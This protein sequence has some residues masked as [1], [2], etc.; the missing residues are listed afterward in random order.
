[1]YIFAA[2]TPIRKEQLD[3]DGFISVPMEF[4]QELNPAQNKSTARE[5]ARQSLPEHSPWDD[6]AEHWGYH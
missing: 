2:L 4:L 3:R 5:L 6:D 1:M